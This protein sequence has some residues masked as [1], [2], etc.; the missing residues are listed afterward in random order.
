[1]IKITWVEK[2][3][4]HIWDMHKG[5]YFRPTGSDSIL[6][7]TGSLRDAVEIKTGNVIQIPD[8]MCLEKLDN[9]EMRVIL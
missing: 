5:D 7:K 8:T 9:V 4:L 3:V 2:S 6:L 1:M